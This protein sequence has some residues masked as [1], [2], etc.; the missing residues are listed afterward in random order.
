[1]PVGAVIVEDGRVVGRGHNR[2]EAL[3]D[4]TAHAEILAIG[5]ACRSLA[6]PRL[7]G[8]TVYVTMEPCPMCAG[9]MILAR[10]RRLVYGCSD[11]KAGY[12]GTLG[13]LVDDPALNHRVAVTCGVMS[14]ECASL[15]SAFFE[16]RRSRVP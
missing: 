9:A 5:A 3:G 2:V 13:N 8:S 1:V 10:V 14:A 6:V 7:T 11:P 4:P 16:R 15:L 12:A